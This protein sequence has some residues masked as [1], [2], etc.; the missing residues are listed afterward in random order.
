[1]IL[2]WENG[3]WFIDRFANRDYLGV[4]PR[5]PKFKVGDFAVFRRVKVKIEWCSLTI[6]EDGTQTF[7]YD[8]KQGN[9]HSMICLEDELLPHIP[10][11]INHQA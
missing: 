11:V 6:K 4:Q 10:V 5:E 9:N 8:V 2:V 1:M 3:K 7:W